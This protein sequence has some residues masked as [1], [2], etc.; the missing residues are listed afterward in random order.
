MRGI[1]IGESAELTYTLLGNSLI[2]T[3]QIVQIMTS[4]GLQSLSNW[5][6]FT[7]ATQSLTINPVKE[8]EG[9]LVFVSSV[10]TQVFSTDFIFVNQTL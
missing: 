4:E 8:A 6:T 1:F 7:H 2:Q 9:S 10:Y 5:M 3:V